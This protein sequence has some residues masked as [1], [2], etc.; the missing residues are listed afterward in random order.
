MVS[1]LCL[2]FLALPSLAW[3]FELTGVFNWYHEWYSQ[4]GARG[5]FGP[6]NVDNGATTRAANLNFWNGHQFDTNITTGAK[7][8]W[9]YFNVEF[10]PKIKINEAIR[11]S[12]KLRLGTYNDPIA[13]DYHTYDAPGVNRPFS[14]GQWTMFWV[15]AQTPLGSLGIGKRPW[16]FGTGLQYDGAEAAT[17]ESI[18]LVAPFG[19]VDI[20]IAFYPYRFIGSSSIAS[21]TWAANSAICSHRRRRPIQL[22][23]ICPGRWYSGPRAVFQSC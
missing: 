21:V 23:T 20:G 8:N 19:P 15:A 4:Q 14:E 18:A 11:F 16:I 2:P 17:T 7:A 3:E 22:A 9:S 12:A 13:S 1:I 10:L 5:F 6:Y